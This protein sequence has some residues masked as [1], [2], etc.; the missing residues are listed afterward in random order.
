M[1]V[2]ISLRPFCCNKA[3]IFN[4]RGA[5]PAV[6][7]NDCLTSWHLPYLS[8]TTIAAWVNFSCG[9]IVMKPNRGN[10]IRVLM[11]LNLGNGCV[12]YLDCIQLI[13]ADIDRLSMENRRSYAVCELKQ[14]SLHTRVICLGSDQ[15]KL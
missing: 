4:I 14:Y 13:I 3:K 11:V 9:T 2:S 6:N 15:L 12:R 5:L 1:A 8:V 7:A 10:V